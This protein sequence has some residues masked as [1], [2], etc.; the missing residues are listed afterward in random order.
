MSAPPNEGEPL[1]IAHIDGQD[2]QRY[3]VLALTPP[4]QD[5]PAAQDFIRRV[6]ENPSA[7]HLQVLLQNGFY[8]RAAINGVSPEHPPQ[9]P[10]GDLIVDLYGGSVFRIVHERAIPTPLTIDTRAFAVRLH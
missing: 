6:L 10:L 1:R 8:R 5:D 7:T 3:A 9:R 4:C 2:G